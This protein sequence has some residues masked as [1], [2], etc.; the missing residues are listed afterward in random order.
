[1][2]L[3]KFTVKC[4]T[5]LIATLAPNLFPMLNKIKEIWKVHLC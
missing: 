2:G 3:L 1:M 4:H 5:L